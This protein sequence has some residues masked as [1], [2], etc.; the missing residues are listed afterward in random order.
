MENQP[1]R[2]PGKIK[3]NLQPDSMGIQLDANGWPQR[4]ESE[5]TELSSGN[6]F[7]IKGSKNGGNTVTGQYNYDRLWT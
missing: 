7:Q 2:G 1:S 4:S 3:I 6:W 5:V